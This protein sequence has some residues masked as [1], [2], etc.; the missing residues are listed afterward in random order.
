MTIFKSRVLLLIS[1]ARVTLSGQNSTLGKVSSDKFS[2][3]IKIR[4]LLLTRVPSFEAENV[5]MNS[6][7]RLVADLD[8]YSCFLHLHK[9][10][11]K[12]TDRYSTKLTGCA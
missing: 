9:S 4:S 8:S 11:N 5:V 10:F 1:P 6:S 7:V 3:D 2:S 12:G